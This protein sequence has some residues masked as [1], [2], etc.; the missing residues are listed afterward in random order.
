MEWDEEIENGIQITN[1][2]DYIREIKAIRDKLID[3]GSSATLFFRGQCNCAWDIRP[4]IFRDSMIEGE[5]DMIEM[6]LSRAPY[7]FSNCTSVFD[8]LTKLQHYGLPTRLL[9]VTMNPLVALYFAC[10]SNGKTEEKDTSDGVVYYGSEYSHHSNTPDV[11]VL[12]ALAK[13]KVNATTTLKNLKES[14]GLEEESPTHLIQLIQGYRFVIPRY[15][16]N[17]L[18]SQNGA[19]LIS[20]AILINE[21]NTDIWESTIA[22]ST[23]NLN[24]IF[25][26]GQII[27]PSDAKEGILSELDFLNINEASLFPEL[28]HQMAHIR[29]NRIQEIRTLIPE[30]VKYEPEKSK[31]IEQESSSTDKEVITKKDVEAVAA[32]YKTPEIVDDTIMDIIAL[33]DWDKKNSTISSLKSAVKRILLASGKANSKEMADSI[34]EDLLMIKR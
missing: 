19:F 16:N 9:D 17:R 29:Q 2:A 5:A 7:E 28:E 22:K 18:V 3:N 26:L 12:A 32:K 21:N 34:I 6:A 14:L 4:S 24:F 13:L 20:G 23:H 30:F 15:G 8:E 25:N 11:R 33:P 31:F 1:I 27:I 10:Y